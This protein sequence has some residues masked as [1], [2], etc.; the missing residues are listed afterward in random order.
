MNDMTALAEQLKR[1]PAALRSLM[2]SPDGQALLRML[3]QGDQGAGLRQAAQARTY[4]QGLQYLMR[5]PELTGLLP[6]VL[7]LFTDDERAGRLITPRTGR[8]TVLLGEDLQR[9]LPGLCFMS[10]RYLAGGGLT[11]AIALLGPT[12][13]PFEQLVPVLDYFALKL[14]ECMAGKAQED[15]Q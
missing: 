5:W 9:P 8:T 3:T 1:N 11:G 2:Q 14:G 7:E 12:R 6:R 10:K 4:P 15:P 13:M